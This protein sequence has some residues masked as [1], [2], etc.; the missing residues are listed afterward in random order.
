MKI[1]ISVNSPFQIIKFGIKF[2]HLYLTKEE[3]E[4]M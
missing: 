3:V 1:D 4:E 2:K